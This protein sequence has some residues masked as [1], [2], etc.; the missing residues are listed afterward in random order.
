MHGQLGEIQ[1]VGVRLRSFV[2]NS[3][4][5]KG[6]CTFE[7]ISFGVGRRICPGV[8]FGIAVV[9]LILVQLL[10]H[11]D[12]KLPASEKMED[13]DM[14]EVFGVTV[15]RKMDLCFVHISYNS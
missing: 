3:V 5:Y 11:F 4:D 15:G 10:Y 12:W 1:C 8:T 14:T 9:E 6:T 7:Y 2:D 13:L